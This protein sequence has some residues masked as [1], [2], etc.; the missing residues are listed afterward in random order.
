M[1]GFTRHLFVT[2]LEA[3]NLTSEWEVLTNSGVSESSVP[4]LTQ[5]PLCPVVSRVLFWVLVHGWEVGSSSSLF[6]GH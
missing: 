1:S 3:G 6:W 2:I 5:G 4:I